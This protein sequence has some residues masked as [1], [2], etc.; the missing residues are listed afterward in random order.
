MKSSFLLFGLAVALVGCGQQSAATDSRVVQLHS[1]HKYVDSMQVNVTVPKLKK[2]GYAIVTDD[3]VMRV[4]RL[5]AESKQNLAK[6]DAAD[7]S[8]ADQLSELIKKEGAVLSMIKKMQTVSVQDAQQRAN[9]TS[10]A[11]IL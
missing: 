11:K 3:E 4:D 7:G 8:Q 6:L 9:E 1:L 2:L 5:L 10:A